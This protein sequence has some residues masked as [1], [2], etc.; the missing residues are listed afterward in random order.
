MARKVI[1]VTGGAGFIGSHLV[2]ELIRRRFNVKVIDNLSVTRDNVSRL[3]DLGAELHVA[4]ISNFDAISPIF[5]GVDGVIHLAAMNRAQRSIDNPIVA[6]KANIDGTINVL[7]SCR[8]N[9]VKRVVNISSSSVYGNSLKYPRHEDN[10][11]IPPHPYGVGKLAGENYAR[12][13]HELFGIQTA[14]ARLFSVFGP[15]QRPDITYAA[16][17]PKFIHNIHAGKPIEVY[18]D[19]SQKRS[20]TFVSDAV[21]GILSVY[22]KARG[23]GEVYNIAAPEEVSINDLVRE[24]EFVTGKKAIIRNTPPLKGDPEKNTVDIRRASANLGFNAKFSLRNG[25]KES[26]K[27]ILANQNLFP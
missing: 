25:L 1:L 11:L 18:G 9:N 14:T 6:H 21:H 5:D 15:R 4:D 13:F 23:K 12:V 10:E 24:I 27:W 7:E 20:F 3:N 2:D 17:I 8:I 19:G 26:Y 16:V 22:E